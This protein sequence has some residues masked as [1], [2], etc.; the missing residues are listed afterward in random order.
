MVDDMLRYMLHPRS[1]NASFMVDDMLRVMVRVTLRPQNRTGQ[2]R[3][4]GWS[5]DSRWGI[6]RD[7]KTAGD[8][9]LPVNTGSFFHFS[10]DFSWFWPI[11]GI[12]GGRFSCFRRFFKSEVRYTRTENPRLMYCTSE[13]GFK[14][15]QLGPSGVGFVQTVDLGLNHWFPSV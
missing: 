3:S 8:E 7:L 6:R 15:G 1:V 2:A 12:F 13:K 10:G 9:V 14:A 11:S 4:D 5:V